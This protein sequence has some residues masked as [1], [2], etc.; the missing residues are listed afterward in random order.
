[1]STG[2]DAVV[3]AGEHQYVGGKGI[4]GGG[5]VGGRAWGGAVT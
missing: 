5:G 4:C 1:M 3:G 2:G